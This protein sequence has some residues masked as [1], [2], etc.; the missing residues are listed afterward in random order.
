MAINFCSILPELFSDELDR[1]SMWTRIGEGIVSASKKCGG[2]YEIF[3][4][5]VL[6]FILAVP[7][8]T[9]ANSRLE[10]WLLSM[11]SYDEEDKKEFL[12]VVSRKNNVILV[13]ARQLWK[14]LKEVSK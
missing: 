13:Y 7:G 4:N 6:E 5:Y 3:V 10:E 11:E 14:E 2:D 9:A 8:M 12:R 1:K